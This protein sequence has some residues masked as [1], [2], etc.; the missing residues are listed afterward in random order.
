MIKSV[1]SSYREIL[2]DY[3]AGPKRQQDKYYLLYI[4][5]RHLCF[6]VAAVFIALGVSANTIT[7]IGFIF[8]IV[9]YCL[10]ISGLSEGI[11][12]GAFFYFAAFI[13]DFADG[14]VA[15]FSKRPNYFGKLIDGL[16]DYF[17]HSLYLFLGIAL[18]FENK[19]EIQYVNWL[20]LGAFTSGLVHL[21]LYFRMRVAY[22]L[23]EIHEGVGSKPIE[24]PEKPDLSARSILAL[25]NWLVA[26][27]IILWPPLLVFSCLLGA[28]DLFLISALLFYLITSCTEIPLRLLRLR[29]LSRVS[30]E[31]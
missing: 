8:Q 9:A 7:L 4:V 15:R 26:N 25:A 20:V 1:A 24:N 16:V 13:L 12:V 22:F 5:Y 6:P 21:I 14:T 10:I 30:R 2:Q 18:H 3:A 17:Q 23:S 31:L 27:I 29:R 19:T 28:A 11:I